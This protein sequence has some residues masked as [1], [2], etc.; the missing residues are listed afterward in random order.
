MLKTL[1]VVNAGHSQQV[2]TAGS[3]HQGYTSK[4]ERI[5][6]H[7]LYYVMVTLVCK[8]HSDVTLIEFRKHSQKS[9]KMVQIQCKPTLKEPVF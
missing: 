1:I 8:T 2:G 7:Q 3:K 9:L 6:A 4:M 5:S